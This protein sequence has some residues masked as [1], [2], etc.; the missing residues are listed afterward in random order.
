MLDLPSAVVGATLV[1]V[2]GSVGFGVWY[3]RPL[4][5]M[6]DPRARAE[7]ALARKR[8]S[9]AKRMRNAWRSWMAW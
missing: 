1:V 9:E 6:R 2:V 8:E 7:R 3:H 4:S 5:G